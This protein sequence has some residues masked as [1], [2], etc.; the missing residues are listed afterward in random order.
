VVV[1]FVVV[2]AVWVTHNTGRPAAAGSTAIPASPI[3]SAV[4]RTSEPPWSTPSDVPAAVG[5][6]GL[7]LLGSEGAV[8]HIHAHLD[9]IVNG[10]PVAV[11]ADI[12]IDQDGDRISPG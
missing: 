12:G 5:Q 7:P 4:G 6:A 10:Q 11:P 9:L 3:T 2:L 1:G 8:E